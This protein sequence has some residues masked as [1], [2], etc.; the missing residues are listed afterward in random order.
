VEQQATKRFI[1]P[2]S[3]KIKEK[4]SDKSKNLESRKGI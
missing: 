3:K 4:I 2:E 1:H